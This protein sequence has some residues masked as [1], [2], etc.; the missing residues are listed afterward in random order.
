MGREVERGIIPE[1]ELVSM[2]WRKEPQEVEGSDMSIMP[3]LN[4]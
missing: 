3:C 2:A 4:G 1:G